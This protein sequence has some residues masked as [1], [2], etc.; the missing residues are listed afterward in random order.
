[1]SGSMRF[2][3]QPVL[4][5]RSVRLRPFREDDLD[6]L[7]EMLCDE[8]GRRLTG[9][10]AEFTREA[11]ERWYR[12]RGRAT[13]RL[14]LAIAERSTDRCV[15]EV[16]LYSLDPDNRSCAFRIS[17]VGPS[18]YDKG[19]GTEATRLILAHAFETVGIHRVELEVYVLNPR[20]RHVYE[21]LGF[22]VEGVFRDALWWDGRFHDAI[23][24]A[25]LA[26]EWARHRGRQQP[27]RLV[28]EDRPAR[29]RA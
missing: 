22:V 9:T 28:A 14:D 11:A 25:M 26:P 27:A 4:E 24:M 12:S 6:L 7:W 1:M 20:A 13:D 17:L 18:V 8:E 29:S 23:A 3:W 2:A 5:G 16:V 19:Y 21:K 15:G 10:H